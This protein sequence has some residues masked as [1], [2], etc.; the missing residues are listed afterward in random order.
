MSKNKKWTGLMLEV[1]RL[2]WDEGMDTGDI[3]RST[4]LFVSQVLKAVR[5][6]PDYREQLRFLKK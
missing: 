3:A 6:L 4:K 5:P 1:N 2:K